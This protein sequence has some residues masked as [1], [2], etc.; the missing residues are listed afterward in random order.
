MTR[1]WPSASG[2]GGHEHASPRRRCSAA[3][4]S[5][6]GGTWRSPPA[7]KGAFWSGSAR[8]V[9][10]W[11]DD[12]GSVAVMRGRPMSGWL[13]V[14]ADDIRHA[15]AGKWVDLGVGFARPAGKGI[16]HSTMTASL[17]TDPDVSASRSE[18]RAGHWFRSKDPDL[19]VFKR[20]LRAAVVMPLVFALTHSSS[21]IHRSP[22]SGRLGPLRSCCWSSSPGDPRTRI[23]SYGGLYVVGACFIVLGTLV[24]THKVAAVV[25][26]GIVGFAV[27]FA[28][29]VAPQAATATTA[30]LLTFV[31]PVAVAQ[32]VS[33]IGPRLIGWT[34]AGCLLHRR[35]A[36]ACGRRPGT[37]ISGGGSLRRFRPSPGWPTPAPAATMTRRRMPTSPMS[38]SSSSSNSPARPILRQ[39]PRRG[40]WR[41]PSWWAG[42]NGL[43]ATAP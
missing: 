30:A 17:V 2:P 12:E 36:C 9:G 41:S 11:F 25:T 24:S 1:I 20:S 38:C 16:A 6:S 27:L 14:G 28:G 37:T 8:A 33:A 15:S 31:L 10:H 43:P 23:T 29:I 34:I 39:A 13:R 19:L 21:R 35:P 22:C 18:R 5:S 26:M 32:P 40:R 4:P 7:A 3:S 42:S